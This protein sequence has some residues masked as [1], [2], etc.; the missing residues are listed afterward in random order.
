MPL[1]VPSLAISWHRALLYLA[2]WMGTQVLWLSQAYK[3][4]FLG[5]N[6]FYHLWICSMIHVVGHSWVLGGI[7]DRYGRKQGIRI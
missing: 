7:M 1:L 2:I 6:V 3:L 5:D 4:E